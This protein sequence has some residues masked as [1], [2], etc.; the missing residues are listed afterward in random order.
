VR[1]EAI[2]SSNSQHTVI[3]NNMVYHVNPNYY[4][5]RL[6]S[7]DAEYSFHQVSNNNVQASGAGGIM[8]NISGTGFSQNCVVQGNTVWTTSGVAY[9]LQKS[10]YLRFANNF[11]TSSG[12]VS[13]VQNCL[14]V[15]YSG[16]IL[17]SGSGGYGISFAGT[18][19]GSIADESNSF[20]AVV[21]N[22]S[23]NG[24]IISKY[25]NAGPTGS[26][27]WAVGDRVIQSVP[28]V[29]QPKGWRCTVAGNPGTWVS[30]GNL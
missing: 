1:G 3:N 28:V 24:T 7:I 10:N 6:T 27:F 11:G 4:A 14:G 21:E 20:N 26:G 29:G 19:T 18:N 16:N 22:Q 17:Y 30:E 15:R 5:I 8:L 25:G 2:I 9:F 13:Y 23:G 12:A